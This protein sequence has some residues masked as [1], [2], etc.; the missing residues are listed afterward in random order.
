[1]ITVIGY[2][3]ELAAPVPPE[4][5]LV[6]GGRRHLDAAQLPS[7]TRTLVM[8]D[9]GAAVTAILAHDGDAAVLAS[10]DPG[11][12][13]V[14]RRL[15]TAG[16][17]LRVEPAASSVALAFARAGLAWEDALVVSV[18]GRDPRPA[19]AA[20]RAHPKLAVLTDAVCGP[21]QVGAALAGTGRTLVVCERLG[22][23]D[24]RVERI[25]PEL[26]AERADWRDPNVVLVLA[27]DRVREP[28]WVAGHAGA[29]AGW[30]L[31]DDAFEHRGGMVTKR[32]VRAQ[33]LAQLAPRLGALVWDV[34][35][36]CGSVAVEC[37][38]FG[39]AVVAVE[40]DAD[41]VARVE[42]NARRH[43]VELQVVAGSA[44][45]CLGVLPDP[46]AVFVGGGGPGVVSACV[47][48]TPARLVV[49]LAAVERVGPTWQALDAGGY[50][51]A[52]VQLQ[53]SRLSPLPDGATRLAAQNPVFLVWGERR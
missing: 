17:L 24:E 40:R 8:G 1:M 9:V 45:G 12:F 18:H 39:A 32:E 2:D 23:A 29:P 46:D 30:A 5:T 27:E 3:G 33:V 4:A 21:A 13:G 15:R 19:L 36:G 7:G 38:R 25:S 20:C 42:R 28:S 35:A 31:P 48:R 11:F 14:V 34:G 22:E 53:A 41:Q 52:G 26:A 50:R 49:A 6:A 43:D 16:A 44:P 51:V 47:A 37:A 10:G